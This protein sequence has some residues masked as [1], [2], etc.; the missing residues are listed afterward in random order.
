MASGNVAMMRFMSGFG[1]SGGRGLRLSALEHPGRLHQEFEPAGRGDEGGA[2]DG[3]LRDEFG[4]A[5]EVAVDGPVAAPRL[6]ADH[7]AGGD[8]VARLAQ[9]GAGD[10]PAGGDEG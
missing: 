2:S 6:E 5:Q 8:V 9:E 4:E 3:G 1:R 10:E 7:G